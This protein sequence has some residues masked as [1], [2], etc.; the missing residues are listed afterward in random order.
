MPA[1]NALLVAANPPTKVGPHAS[2]GKIKVVS[3]TFTYAS[4]SAASYAI[5]GGLIPA[6]ARVLDAYFV[7]SVTTG[8]ATLA[9]GIAGTTGKY[10]TAAAVTTANQ[11]TVS[12][13][14]VA[15]LT[16]ITTAEQLLLTVASASL[17]ASGTL[18]IVLTYVID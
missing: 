17:P 13:N 2:G 11:R 8:S 9:L 10:I 18:R 7:T 16:E 5:G 4:D 6:G 3:E 12:V 15:L 1:T 14:Q